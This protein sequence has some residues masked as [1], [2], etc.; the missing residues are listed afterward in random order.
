MLIV[1]TEYFATRLKERRE[2]LKLSQEDLADMIRSSQ[3]QV[4]Q[5]EA[6]KITPRTDSLLRLAEALQ[7]TPNYLLGLTDEPERGAE[8]RGLSDREQ[9]LLEI[10]RKLPDRQREL[11]EFA[12][13]MSNPRD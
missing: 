9:Q 3:K 1:T 11:L 4:S 10:F 6:G 2:L 7:T 13:I 8:G 12:R 5:W